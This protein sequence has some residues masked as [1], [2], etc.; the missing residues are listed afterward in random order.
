MIFNA[1]CVIFVYCKSDSDM[2]LTPVIM[3]AIVLEMGTFAQS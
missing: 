1:V 2:V 3:A